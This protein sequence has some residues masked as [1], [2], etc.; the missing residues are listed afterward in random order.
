M[1]QEIRDGKACAEQTANE[2]II[3]VGNV[4]VFAS[5]KADVLESF[6]PIAARIGDALEKEPGTIRV[7]GH[8]D[9]QRIKSIRFPSNYELSVD[10]ARTVADLIRV[11]ISRPERLVVEGKGADNPIAPNATPEGRSKNRRVE[12][13]IPRA[14][15][16]V[17]NVPACR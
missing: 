5:G 9:N 10:R 1:A 2:I 11:R 13:I 6:R 16:R 7:V 8:T 12:I 17:V 14:D 4:A 3:T 15:D